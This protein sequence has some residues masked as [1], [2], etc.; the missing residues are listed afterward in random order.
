MFF[1]S[2]FQAAQSAM[3]S[4]ASGKAGFSLKDERGLL[5]PIGHEKVKYR[6]GWAIMV[7]I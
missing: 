7:Q 4:T 2:F 5:Y 3:V 1:A 6:I